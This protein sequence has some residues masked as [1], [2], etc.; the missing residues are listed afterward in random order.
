MSFDTN[1]RILDIITQ[2]K[3]MGHLFHGMEDA[4]IVLTKPDLRPWFGGWSIQLTERLT[5]E[6][7]FMFV[8]IDAGSRPMSH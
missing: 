6:Q 7:L 1:C 3:M 4:Y 2:W 8:K 5:Q